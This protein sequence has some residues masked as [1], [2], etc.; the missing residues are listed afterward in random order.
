MLSSL[1]HLTWRTHSLQGG[2]SNGS[3]KLTDQV[4]QISFGID[5]SVA[6]TP[7]YLKFSQGKLNIPSEKILSLSLQFYQHYFRQTY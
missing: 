4:C 3:S 7:L 5:A 2:L 1:L 6:N